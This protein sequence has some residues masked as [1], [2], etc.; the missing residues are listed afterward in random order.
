[1]DS[2]HIDDT[3]KAQL[4][5]LRLSTF[6]DVYFE[7]A[8]DE[9]VADALPEDIF[10]KA[11]AEAAEQRRQRNIAKAITHAKFRYPDATL[12]ELIN[13]EER[14][15]NLR[16]LKRLAATNWRE[17]PTNV[18]LLA[19]TGTGKTYIA[20]A[21]GIA[22]CQAGYS[23]AYFRLDQ[24]VDALAVLLPADK[25]YVDLVR[26]LQNVDVLI[27]DDFLTIGINQ[28]GQEDLTKII[29]D[30]DGRLPTIVASQTSAA[31]WLESLS[32][33][34]GA[35]SLVSRLN[36]G[37]RISIGDYDMRQHLS[38]TNNPTN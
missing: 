21:I 30:R 28:R 20:C 29:F 14:G 35:D 17:T 19:P 18:H 4:R 36:S 31:Y 11:V 6:A 16:Q 22:A 15:I 1:M 9:T 7:L 33:R 38:Y 3:T 34:V 2:L 24:L 23:V 27:L 10:L 37:Q 26:R 32:D 8:A 25:R 12:T 13:V 5:Q